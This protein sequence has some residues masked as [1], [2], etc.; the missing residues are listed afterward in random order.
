MSKLENLQAS[1]RELSKGADSR[2]SSARASS[3]REA[4]ELRQLENRLNKATMK[5]HESQSL[6]STYEQVGGCWELGA[7]GLRLE[8][9]ESCT[10]TSYG[11]MFLMH[12]LVCTRPGYRIP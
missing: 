11:A 12:W 3:G 7:L 2:E 9:K 8:I 6:R 5:V 1:V 10:D 4:R